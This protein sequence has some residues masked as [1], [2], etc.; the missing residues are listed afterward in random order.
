MGK[1][2][3]KKNKSE[4][5]SEDEKSEDSK[6]KGKKKKNKKRKKEPEVKDVTPIVKV[7]DKKAIVDQYFSNRNQYHIY[8]DDENIFNG[9][10]FSCTLN[11][12][13]L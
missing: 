10:F 4:D 5:K 1:K 8:Q 2:K 11:K 3:T 6:P 13:D 7:I 12:S 9:S